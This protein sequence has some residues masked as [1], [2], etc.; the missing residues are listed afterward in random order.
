MPHATITIS[1]RER[2]GFRDNAI[3][4]AANKLSAGVSVGIGGHSEKIGD[5]QFNINDERSVDEV[6]KSVEN[7]GF[8]PLMSEYIYV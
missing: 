1:T 2:A 8:Y 5:E 4:I 6:C 3:K 7:S